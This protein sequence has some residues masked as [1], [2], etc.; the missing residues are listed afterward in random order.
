MGGTVSPED[1]VVADHRQFLFVTC[2]SWFQNS[3]TKK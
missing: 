3:S 2:N 1:F